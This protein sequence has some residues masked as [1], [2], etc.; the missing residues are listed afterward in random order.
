MPPYYGIPQGVHASLR[1]TT[2][3]TC[4]PTYGGSREP[5]MVLFPLFEALG[6]LFWLLFLLFEALGSLFCLSGLLFP[7]SEALGSL[8]G[9]LCLL[10]EALGSLLC[11][12]G[13]LLMSERVPLSLRTVINVRTAP[14]RLS[15]LPRAQKDPFHCWRTV[16]AS[17]LSSTLMSERCL[18]WALGRLFLFPVS[19]LADSS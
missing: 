14:L 12:S 3:C 17:C 9:L 11:L 6:S 5:L 8:S 19:L 18:L 4:L 1:Y 2:G 13:L 15:G 7:L 10:S 16:L